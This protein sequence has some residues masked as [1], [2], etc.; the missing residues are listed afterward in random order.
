LQDDPQLKKVVP[1]YITI[2]EDVDPKLK[3]LLADS[4]IRFGQNIKTDAKNALFSDTTD[5]HPVITEL[6]EKL[7]FT[8]ASFY[9]RL[10]AIANEVVKFA[11]KHNQKSDGVK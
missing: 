4:L 7:F 3:I 11:E 1:T 5:S 6:A 2:A 8:H 10:I 9:D